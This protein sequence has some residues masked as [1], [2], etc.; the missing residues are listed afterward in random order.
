MRPAMSGFM[1]ANDHSWLAIVG[2]TA[3]AKQLADAL[4]G[5]QLIWPE[6]GAGKGPL[7][8]GPDLAQGVRAIIDASHPFDITL[9]SW[10]ASVSDVAYLRLLR[11]EWVRGNRDRWVPID[12]SDMLPNLIDKGARVFV[13][14]GRE[15]L[16]GFKPLKAHIFWRSV[17]DE[18]VN[19]PLRHSHVIAS[20]GPFT[21]Q[22]E[23]QLFRKLR[24]D[25]LVVRN[26]GGQGAWPK[27]EAARRLGVNVAMLE[28]PKPQRGP[29]VSSVKE[30]LEWVR[31]QM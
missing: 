20:K 1:N 6:K 5:S 12:R 17:G 27:I 7:R 31:H 25:W 26:A 2:G 9:H 15:E 11:P 16:A 28:R 21:V 18:I 10:A 30:G 24:I 29:V 8:H 13:A 4:P 14:T 19:L 23:M 3:E 22:G